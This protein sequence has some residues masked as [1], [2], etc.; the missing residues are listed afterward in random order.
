MHDESMLKEPRETNGGCHD[1]KR[2]EG[3][4]PNGF[5]VS[6]EEF[7]TFNGGSGS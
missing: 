2:L 5:C 3:A 6:T 4:S 1:A 7:K